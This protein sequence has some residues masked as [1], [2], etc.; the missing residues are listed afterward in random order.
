M[1]YA[2]SNAKLIELIIN[3]FSTIIT[4]KDFHSFLELIFDQI[5]KG[6]NTI[7]HFSFS[8]NQVHPHSPGVIIYNGQKYLYPSLLVTR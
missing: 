8:F 4:S 6:I 5:K 2:I 7:K 3:K 1:Y